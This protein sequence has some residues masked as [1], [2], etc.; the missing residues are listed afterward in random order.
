MLK[1]HATI[2]NVMK[3][4]V[5][6]LPKSTIELTVTVEATQVKAMYD[7][8]LNEAVES[9]T[10][11]GFRAGKAPK[12]AVEQKLGVSKL[13]ADV[14]D[15]L[16][17]LYYPQALK[18]NHIFAISNPRVEIKEFDLE[19]DFIFTAQIPVK[20]EVKIAEFKT[21]LKKTFEDQKAEKKKENEQKLKD[22]QPIDSD[23]IHL[24][25]NTVIDAITNATTT[26]L[27][28]IIIEEET[29]RMMARLVDQ[30]QSIGLSLDEYLK[31]QN[32]TK[33]DLR[34]DYDKVAERN[35]KAEFA[36]A[37][38][39]EQEKVEISEQEIEE[40]IK[41]SGTENTEALLNDPL[42]KMYVKSILQKSKVISNII[43][44]IEGDHAHES[45]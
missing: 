32:K 28:E 1:S 4:E 22:G 30:A 16:L 31:S 13:Y 19:K 34:K 14:I 21:A 37:Q 7:H 25:S 27:P 38:L 44:E 26:E 10:I 6:K 45:L 9:T 39:V 2:K 23:H 36:L 3:A 5:K 40:L 11:A 20:P 18:E 35:V 29:N 42:Q 33:E 24:S 15:H 43:A 8:V 41:A 17:Q 12:E